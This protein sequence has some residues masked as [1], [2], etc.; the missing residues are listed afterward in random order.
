MLVHARKEAVGTLRRRM[1]RFQHICKG[2]NNTDTATVRKKKNTYISTTFVS[3][4][5]LSGSKKNDVW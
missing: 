4:I 2:C 3:F 1:C 5:G